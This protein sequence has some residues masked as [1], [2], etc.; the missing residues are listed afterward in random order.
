MSNY[1]PLTIDSTILEENEKI[2]NPTKNKGDYELFNVEISQKKINERGKHGKHIPFWG[3]NPNILFK[4]EYIFEFFP[5]DEMSINEKL[6][7][8]TRLVIILTFLGFFLTRHYRIF[9]VSFITL[10]AIYLYH[11]FYEKEEKEGFEYQNPAKQVLE[12]NSI[13]VSPD[14][15][16]HSESINPF[17]NVLNTDFDYNPQKKSAAPAYNENVNILSQAKKMVNEANPGQPNISDKLFK[18]LGD[19]LDFEQ[20]MRQFYSNPV[21]TIPNDQQGFSE[22]CYGSMVSCKEGNLFACARNLSRYTL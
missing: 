7:A 3:K 15:F 2:D 9:A 4:N 18:G 5:T 22:F 20:S 19:E 11:F 12:N 21:T 8:I 10:F 17:S 13:E 14:V 6:N 16:Q 1:T